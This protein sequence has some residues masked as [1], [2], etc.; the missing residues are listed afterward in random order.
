[1]DIIEFALEMELDG[2]AFY[3]RSAAATSDPE[4]KEM[5]TM[6]AEEEDRH[7]R[8]FKRLKDGETE[9]AAKE[10]NT[11]VTTLHQAKNIF[12]DLSQREIAKPFGED[13]VSAWKEAL[14][15]EEKAEKFYREKANAE[16]NAD[17]RRLLNLIADEELNHV[18]MIDGILTYLKYPDTFADST[19]FKSFMSWEGH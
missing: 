10:L 18:H 4:L 13:V 1:M 16:R 19:Q 17:R 5:L 6:L 12:E 15:I 3:Q 2:K 8:F 9:L 7:Y 11:R 14:R